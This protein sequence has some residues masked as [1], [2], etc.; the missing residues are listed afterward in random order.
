MFLH[1][2]IVGSD[3]AIHC[4]ILKR[5]DQCLILSLR[6]ALSLALMLLQ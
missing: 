4:S 3:G 5:L 6:V 1:Y 2:L